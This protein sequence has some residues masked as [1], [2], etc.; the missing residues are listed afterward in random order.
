VS[1]WLEEKSNTVQSVSEV[2]A[3]Q[4]KEVNK[5]NQTVG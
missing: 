1:L 2:A 3:E 5:V 4:K